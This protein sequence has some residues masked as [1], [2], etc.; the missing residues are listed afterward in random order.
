MST[1]DASIWS[2]Y[3]I[4]LT[5]PARSYFQRTLSKDR[6]SEVGMNISAHQEKKETKTG[7]KKAGEGRTQATDFREAV[8]CP[9]AVVQGAAQQ[10]NGSRECPG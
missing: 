2:K 3:G 4:A 7:M 1:L 10:K 6:R 8:C 9:T 5:Y